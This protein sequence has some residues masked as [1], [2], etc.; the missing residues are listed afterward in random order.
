MADPELE[1][2]RQQRLAQLQSQYKGGDAGNQ[3]A[4]EEKQRQ[5]E[6]FRHSI[7]AQVLDQSARAR[8]NTLSLGRPEKAKMV[9]EMLVS[10][11]QRGQLPGRLGEEELIRLLESV[12][13]QTRKTTTVKF[14]RR[15][16]ALDS[17]DDL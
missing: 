12:N 7:L 13:Q 1:A 11:A 16:A 2:L 5:I 17:D 8:L 15:R 4:A 14:D 9:E 3:Q 10:M 6:E